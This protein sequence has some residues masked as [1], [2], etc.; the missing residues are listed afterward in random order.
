M[1]PKLYFEEQKAVYIAHTSG[2]LMHVM[3]AMLAIIIGPFQ[4]L[5][6]SITRR[7]LTLHRWLG[8]SYMVGVLFGGLGG[9]YMAFLAYGGLPAQAGFAL[10][11][12]LWLFSGYMAYQH[13]RN[14]EVLLHRQWMVRN[15]ALTFAGVMLRLWLAILHYVGLS[16]LQPIF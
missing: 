11:A 3:G 1:N 12:V 4:F 16:L 14:R 15:Y 10:L 9:L 8:K 13:I 6:G 2:I 5:P 7:Y